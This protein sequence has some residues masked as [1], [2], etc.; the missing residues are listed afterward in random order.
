MTDQ[1]FKQKRKECKEAYKRTG[2]PYDL[3]GYDNP[4]DAQTLFP[5]FK[6]MIDM[7]Y[8]AVLDGIEEPRGK[9]LKQ[10]LDAALTSHEE[11]FKTSPGNSREHYCNGFMLGFFD[12]IT[13]PDMSID[14]F[15]V[16]MA[17]LS[18]FMGEP[19]ARV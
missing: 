2:N 4:F 10:A 19:Q 16:V 3:I 6:V 12:G 9:F 17:A 8:E 13:L 11:V 7:A 1:E 5:A 15:R 14:T 18:P